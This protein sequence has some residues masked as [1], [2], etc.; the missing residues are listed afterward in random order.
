M[1]IFDKNQ[2]QQLSPH[3]NSNEL[4]CH[5]EKPHSNRIAPE[6]VDLL[7]LLRH[8]LGD[9]PIRVHSAYRCPKYNKQV[10]GVPDSQHV[11]GTAVDIS[12]ASVDLFDIACYACRIHFTGVG[13]YIPQHFIH[14]DIRGKY[15]HWMEG[16]ES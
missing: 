8:T 6:L 10:G 2:H 15:A 12:I 9:F 1:W 16:S 3:F 13:M 11:Q 5:C 7:E 4:Q 14:L